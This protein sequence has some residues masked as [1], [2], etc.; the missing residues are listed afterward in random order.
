MNMFFK[1]WSIFSTKEKKKFIY[2]NFFII[3]ITLLEML[4]VGVIIPFF[5]IILEPEVIIN[6]LYFISFYKFIGSPN[7]INLILIFS[8]IL[9]SIFILKN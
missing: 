6:N 1:I 9:V 5:A 7:D 4:S 3:F 8:G 2:I